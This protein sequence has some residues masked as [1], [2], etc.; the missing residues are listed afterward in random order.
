M[1]FDLPSWADLPLFSKACFIGAAL[2][3]LLYFALVAR[4]AIKKHEK[5]HPD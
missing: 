4:A 1:F 2:G 3:L 5:E